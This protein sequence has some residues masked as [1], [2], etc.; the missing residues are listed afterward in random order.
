MDR[1][2]DSL[3][4]TG[5][6]SLGKAAYEAKQGAFD[7]FTYELELTMNGQTK[8]FE[9]V[10]AWA[11]AEPLPDAIVKAQAIIESFMSH[12][13]TFVAGDDVYS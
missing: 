3:R 8:V 13:P 11:S 1:L 4:A 2:E 7:F 9:W 5:L 10:D 12:L 6:M